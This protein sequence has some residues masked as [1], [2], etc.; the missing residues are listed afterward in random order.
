M[1]TGLPRLVARAPISVYSKLLAAFLLIV[2]LLVS[3]GAVA[4]RMLGEVNHRA[5]EL[6]RLQRKAAA[7]REVQL[8]TTRQLYSVAAVLLVPNERIRSVMSGMPSLDATLRQLVLVSEDLARLPPVQGPESEL[9]DKLRA[10]YRQFVGIAR[11]VLQLIGTGSI[12]EAR[13]LQLTQAIPL[14]ARLQQI[15]SQLVADA[16]AS[17]AAHTAASHR[18]YQTAHWVVLGSAVG[19]IALA[20]LLGYALSGSLIGAVREMKVGLRRIAAGDFSQGVVVANRDE[21][22]VLAADI[23]RMSSELRRLYGQLEAASRHKSEFLANMS[24]ELRTPLNAIMG[25]SEML[26]EEARDT[27]GEA[28]VPD[29]QKI[30]AAGRHLLELINAVLDLSK[31]EAGRMELYLETFSIPGLVHDITAVIQPLVQKNQNRL[32]VTCPDDLGT[33]RADLTKTR[34]AVLNLLSNAC[35]FTERGLV[36]LTVRRAPEDGAEWVIFAVRDTGIGMTPE[37]MTKLFQEFSQADAA[38]T[39]KYGGTGLGLALSR[40]L[41]RLMGGD[42]VTESE[43]GRGSTFTIRLPAHVADGSPGAVSAAETRPDTALAEVGTVLVVDDEPSVRELMHRF[44]SKEGFRVVTAAGGEDGLRLARSL[45]PDVITLDV[46]M[47]GMDGW[48]VLSALKANADT[49]DIPVIMVTIVDDRNL[50]T[51]SEP[52]TTSPSLSTA[53]A[54]SQCSP[55]TGETCRS[56]SSTTMPH[57]ASCSDASWIARDIA[58]WRR[59]TAAWRWTG[60]ARRGRD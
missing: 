10:D 55:G 26:Q 48:A 7:Y 31:I 32:E 17:M 47:P 28:F 16:E 15:T 22:G 39:R 59:K 27:G 35:K 34:Q 8:D 44:L 54:S 25:Y 2:L 30:H 58:S 14:A 33:M 1:T 9:V 41:V 18:A 4:I 42:I 53:S 46:M 52:P 21:L 40:R 19:T 24:H 3:V 38:T 5:E 57:S 43:P 37:Q 50:G 11:N 13:E 6:V 23:N 56:S 49:T 51:P 60:C 12:D 29:L 45:R 20:L 36:A